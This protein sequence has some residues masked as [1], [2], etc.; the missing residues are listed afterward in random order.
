MRQQRPALAYT[1]K[2]PKSGLEHPDFFVAFFCLDSELLEN[3]QVHFSNHCLALDIP[4]LFI[5]YSAPR[6]IIAEEFAST[7]SL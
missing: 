6:F 4:E 1:W 3:L 5:R 7:L 2:F